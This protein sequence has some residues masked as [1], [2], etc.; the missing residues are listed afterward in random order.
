LTTKKSFS[1]SSRDDTAAISRDN[2][3]KH[4]ANS[5]NIE[6]DVIADSRNTN[7]AHYPLSIILT[8]LFRQSAGLIV[9]KLSDATVVLMANDHR[10]QQKMKFCAAVI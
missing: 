1:W 2:M 8:H 6:N 5:E 10:P 9:A 4:H 7:E 3:Q